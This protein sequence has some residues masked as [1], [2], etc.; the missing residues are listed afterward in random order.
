MKTV[1]KPDIQPG[2]LVQHRL[3]NC[4][5]DD[6][7]SPCLV[8]SISYKLT[9]ISGPPRWDWWIEVTQ[10]TECWGDWNGYWVRIGR[11]GD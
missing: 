5:Q 7:Q 10:G 6:L 8:I 9:H 1:K 3:R 4:G 2:D 11:I